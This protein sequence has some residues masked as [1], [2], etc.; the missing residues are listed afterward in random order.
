MSGFDVS[1]DPPCF[2]GPAPAE[3][4]APTWLAAEARELA[5]GVFSE[6]WRAWTRPQ[7]VVYL[8]EAFADYAGDSPRE[9]LDYELD[10]LDY[11]A[12]FIRLA[13]AEAEALE[14]ESDDETPDPFGDVDFDRKTTLEAAR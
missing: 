9:W 4:Q 14:A 6:Q 13:H 5:R 1:T 8:A 12:E 3:E 10:A 7:V 11:A 2:D